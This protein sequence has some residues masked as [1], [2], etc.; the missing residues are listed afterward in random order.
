MIFK[1]LEKDIIALLEN[2]NVNLGRKTSKTKKA[3]IEKIR[4]KFDLATS[5]KPNTP[6]DI[7]KKNYMD[8]RVKCMKSNDRRKIL[9]I[10]KGV[11]AMTPTESARADEQLGRSPYTNKKKEKE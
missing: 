7:K 11:T 4:A 2:S 3:L 6:T 9:D 10:G 1:Q 5:K 8:D